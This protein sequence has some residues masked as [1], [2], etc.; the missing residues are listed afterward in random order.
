[1]KLGHKILAL[2][3]SGTIIT[4]LMLV[5]IV[6][7]RRSSLEH[8][9]L[10]DID[11]KARSQCQWIAENLVDTM[12]II[13]EMGAKQVSAGVSALSRD[14]KAQGV[15]FSDETVP[16]PAVN[17]ETKQLQEIVLPK[18]LVGGNWLGQNRDANTPSMFDDKTRDIDGGLVTIFQRINEAGD[19]LRVS[20]NVMD[21]A[22]ARAIGS[23]IPA[24]AYDGLP[25]PV[26]ARLLH[27]E[28]YVGRA[29]VYDKWCVT[30]Y[31]PILDQDGKVIG[32]CFCGIPQKAF[33][34]LR[35][36]IMNTTV[37]ETGYVY[38]IQGQGKGRGNYV[39]SLKGERDGENVWDVK[40]ANGD[41][42]I[43]K[44]VET[45][46]AAKPGESAIVEYPWM[47]KGETE[48]REKLA[49][50]A[51]YKPWDW[52]I[53]VS[54]YKDDFRASAVAVEHELNLLMIVCT[55]AG[56]IVTGAL[57]VLAVYASRKITQ[58]LVEVSNSLRE[59]AQGDGDLRR[60]LNAT[61]KDET[62]ELAHWFNVF[63][64]KIQS[65]MARVA[66]TAVELGAVS[67]DMFDTSKE[68]AQSAQ[69]TTDQSASVAAAAEEVS[70]TMDGM[71]N[72]SNDMAQ[73]IDSAAAAVEQMTASISA[74]AT[75][76][77]SAANVAEKAA[78][79]VETSN[80]T[81]GRLSEAANE[82]GNVV[83]LIQEI[84][85][86][87]NL[88]ALNATIEAARAGESGKGFA[89]VATEVKELAQQT[90]QATENIRSKIEGIQSTSNETVGAMGSI[91]QT[92]DQVKQVSR[93][94]AAAVHEQSEATQEIAKNVTLT[95]TSA[96][97]FAH[98]LSGSSDASKDIA[99]SITNVDQGARRTLEAANRAQ[100]TG[101]NLARLANQM[102]DLVGR[103]SA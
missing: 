37:G 21:Q 19:M 38:V 96:S 44:I 32:A 49:A 83:Q 33:Q 86:Q 5:S 87:T 102:Q 75:N 17:Q 51:Y 62:G 28:R 41:F 68:L 29:L 63:I 85:E 12:S 15:T 88:L 11:A 81:I 40:D 98:G 53:G 43:R 99:R 58:P 48:A 57:A 10:E 34:S 56:I 13:D 45:A 64:E 97:T 30:A 91:H 31:D 60:R 9:V 59:I 1:M 67:T 70:T 50:V 4:S 92:I 101:D 84:A 47:N 52:V 24:T 2:T 69:H 14:V 18:L 66:T 93:V 54:A 8:T 61:T 77:E 65:I 36:V 3:I 80:A 100:N 78:Q 72:T 95:S 55:T 46:L 79:L 7:L 27:G 35:D 73:S 94:I 71:T 25:N 76:A 22:G 26:V 82:I 6:F 103:F 74:I 23:Y 20:T 90:R 42:A 39:I 16:W 89:V